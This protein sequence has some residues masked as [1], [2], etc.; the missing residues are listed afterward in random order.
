LRTPSNLQ[1]LYATNINSFCKLESISSFEIMNIVT[2]KNILKLNCTPRSFGRSFRNTVEIQGDFQYDN[3]DIGNMIVEFNEKNGIK[4]VHSFADRFNIR[5]D[6][7]S[8]NYRV[9]IGVKDAEDLQDNF[10]DIGNVFVS[11]SG[12]IRFQ[13][14]KLNTQIL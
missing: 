3:V 11:N 1:P 6:L 12:N 14:H 4:A 9:D 5:A 13:A 10:N 8:N 7:I 2:H